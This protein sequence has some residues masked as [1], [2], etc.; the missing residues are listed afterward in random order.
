MLGLKTGD[1]ALRQFPK[2][3][4]TPPGLRGALASVRGQ[5]EGAPL[6]ILVPPKALTAPVKL[7]RADPE[8]VET[9]VRTLTDDK[10]WIFIV[11][12][13]APQPRHAGRSRS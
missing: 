3:N 4:E 12:T 8:V 7:L 2:D 13:D 6:K 9:G 11:V 10:R 5:G 1:G